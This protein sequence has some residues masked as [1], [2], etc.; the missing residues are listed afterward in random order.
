[1]GSDSNLAPLPLPDGISENYVRCD[2]TGLV[3]HILEAGY[4]PERKRPLI[5]LLHGY[6]ELAFSWRKIMPTLAQKGYYCVAPDQRGYGRTTGWPNAPF[7]QVDLSQFT[8]TNL[9]RDLVVLIYAIGYK[10]VHCVIGH[11]FGAVS[12][13]M[14]ALM[15]PDMFTSSVTISHPFPGSPSPPFNV[16][17]SSNTN[18]SPTSLSGHNIAAELAALSEP[19]KHYKWYNSSPLAAHDWKNPPQGLDTFLRDYIYVKSADYAGNN[20][21]PLKE[22][23]AE[24]VATMPY[25]YIMPL[26][27]SMPE[28]VQLMMQ[29]QSASATKKWITDSELKVYVDEWRRTGFQGALN[30][31]RASTG[32]SPATT[33]DLLLFA[34]KRIEVPTLF[35]SGVKDWGSYQQPGAIEKLS[36]TCADFRGARWIKNAGHW[37]QQENPEQVSDEILAFLKTIPA[38]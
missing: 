21:H 24:E 32:S 13:S 17:H 33:R 3:V 4:T 9:V 11:D 34:G 27:A 31:Y 28:A 23:S 35:V 38:S 26:H 25:Y 22:W 19:R 14:C 16:A 6:P 7:D 10:S 18:T 30:W 5:L 15:R 29:D 8:M 20:P 2:A 37:P 36:E 1:M 12:S